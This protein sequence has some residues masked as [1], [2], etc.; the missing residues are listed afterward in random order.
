MKE[1]KGH[2]FDDLEEISEEIYAL[3]QDE[4]SKIKKYFLPT[5]YGL[6]SDIEKDV[7]E[8]K[9][10]MENIRTSIKAEADS[11]KNLVDEVTSE[12]IEHNHT[13][14]K[15]LLKMLES[16][17]TTYDDY[18]AYLGEITNELQ[19]YLSTTNQKLLFS[20]IA[21]IEIIPETTK[22]VP[23]AFIAGR[24][25]KD[26]VTKLLGRVDVPNTEPVSYTHLT[27]P[28]ICSV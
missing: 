21:K 1:H 3:W 11:L 9:K 28:T 16:Q 22:P 14:E 4:I 20:K 8:I 15:S 17:E 2:E 12:N 25:N 18:I 10:I 26:D 23:P 24:F 27:L 19:E 5:T 6:K 13:M 7:T